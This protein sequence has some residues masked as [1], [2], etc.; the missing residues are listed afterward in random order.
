MVQEK[1]NNAKQIKYHFKKNPHTRNK[2]LL[3]LNFGLK[4]TLPKH[5]IFRSLVFTHIWGTF[6]EE[7]NL[8]LVN[9]Q[10]NIQK[11]SSLFHN[12]WEETNCDLKIKNYKQNIL[13]ILYWLVILNSFRC[14]HFKN[15]LEVLRFFL[16]QF[17]WIR[18]HAHAHFMCITHQIILLWK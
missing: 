15:F 13:N 8:F 14:K 11:V 6:W 7:K 5:L 2:F 10:F 12:A 9:K 4:R 3:R 1:W 17:G 16:W 18:T